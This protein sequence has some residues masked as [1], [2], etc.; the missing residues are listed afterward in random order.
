MV[1]TTN[2]PA[3]DATTS[4]VPPPTLEPPPLDLHSPIGIIGTGIAGLITAHVLLR[5]GFT[6]VTLL[7]RDA[8][9][10]GTWARG[11]VYEGL[12]T[13]KYDIFLR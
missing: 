6:S 10:G 2:N 12:F 9:V 5:D 7:S 1:G 3:S 13:N 4:S 11:R 8:S